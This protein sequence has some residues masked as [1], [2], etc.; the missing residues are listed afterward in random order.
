[1]GYLIIVY[2]FY[3]IVLSE[4]FTLEGIITGSIIILCVLYFN[5]EPKENFTPK[6]IMNFRK[7]KYWMLYIMILLKEIVVSNI[8]VARI[9]LSRDLKIS[10]VLIKIKTNIKSDLNKAIYANSITLTPGTLTIILEEDELLVHCLEE[11][12]ALGAQNS[13]FERIIMKVEE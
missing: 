5:R 13:D 11:N 2:L 4:R 10:P 7:L 12:F 6:K 8:L 1:M 9:V 3:W